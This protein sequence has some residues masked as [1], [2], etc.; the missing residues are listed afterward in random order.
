[1]PDFTD[2][3]V[4]AVFKAYPDAVRDRLMALRQLIF[5]TA[6]KTAGVGPLAETL[7]WG[8]PSYLTAASKSGTTIRI[9]QVKSDP[10]GYAIFVNCQ[11]DLIETY[12]AREG[13]ALT[14]AGNRAILF[15]RR[16]KIPDAAV[17]R[18]IVQAL[19]Y[20][21]NKTAAGKS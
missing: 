12:R 13:G 18:C 19:T 20:H 7:K 2:P 17:R 10:D 6:Q 4:A 16:R 15:D 3:A 14:F 11:T 1:V 21:R 5:E 9:D 8:Q